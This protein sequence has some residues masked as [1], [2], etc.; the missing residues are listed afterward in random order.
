M[1]FDWGLILVLG[2]GAIIF[3]LIGFVT[4]SL[5][6]LSEAVEE[7]NVDYEGLHQHVHSLLGLEPPVDLEPPGTQ[8]CRCAWVDE[9]EESEQ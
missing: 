7:I 4:A 6:D 1:N 2:M 5:I 9:L 8:R 3:A